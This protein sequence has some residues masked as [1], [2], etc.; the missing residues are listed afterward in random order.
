MKIKD[1]MTAWSRQCLQSSD[2]DTCPLSVLCDSQPHT[3]FN[4]I[5]DS[6]MR[7][8]EQCL[9]QMSNDYQQDRCKHELRDLIYRSYNGDCMDFTSFVQNSR[10]QT[11]ELQYCIKCGAVFIK[12]IGVKN[13]TDRSK[14]G[15]TKNPRA[16]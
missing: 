16:L 12:D 11:M 3:W 2:C 13:G 4:V 1:M 7:A 5:T 8:I 9:N 6:G 14:T 10:H 15:C